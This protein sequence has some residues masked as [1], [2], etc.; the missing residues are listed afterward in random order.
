ME[1]SAK[2]S[3]HLLNLE[4]TLHKRIVGQDEAVVAICCAVYRAC[5]GLKD[6]NRP[7]TSFIFSGPTGVGK[8]KL[9]KALAAS[10]FGSEEAMIR[11]D[12]S[13][14]MERHTVSKLIGSPS[15]YVG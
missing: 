11:R 12:M 15:G 2:E 8:S 1:V 4:D 3:E 7:I 6:P 5:V 13:E 9:T 14:F 10:Y